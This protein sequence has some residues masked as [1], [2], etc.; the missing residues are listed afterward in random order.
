MFLGWESDTGV[1]QKSAKLEG[2]LRCGKSQ[3]PDSLYETLRYV[4]VCAQHAW[5][6]G[7]HV[8]ISAYY[9]CNMEM[10]YLPSMLVQAE[11][12]SPLCPSPI[13]D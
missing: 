5:V 8:R 2:E 4:H 10:I 9:T 11:V 6:F 13:L 3:V 1:W 7:H 12:L